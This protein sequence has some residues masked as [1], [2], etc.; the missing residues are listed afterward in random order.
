ML[1][2]WSNQRRLAINLTVFNRYPVH[3]EVE[4]IVGDFTSLI[5]LDVDVKPEQTFFTRVKETQA[6]LLDGLEHRHYDG[7]NFI[8]DFTRY[9]QMTPKAVMPIVFTSMLAGAG[10]FSWEQLGSLRY[11]HARTPQ[12]Y[13]DNVVIEKWRVIN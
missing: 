12:V 7:V 9:H 3:D 11:I 2:Y 1:A 8:R 13:L 10:A 5:L 6:T 4:Q